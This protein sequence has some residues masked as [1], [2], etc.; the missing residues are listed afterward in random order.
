MS[1]SF[2][3]FQAYLQEAQA[4]L[5]TEDQRVELIRHARE[6]CPHAFHRNRQI[7]PTFG[8]GLWIVGLDVAPG[9]YRNSDS[10]GLC[11]WA[12]LKGFRGDLDDILADS[13]SERIQTVTIRNGDAAFE[14]E[15]CGEWNPI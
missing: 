5:S 6:Q 8:D 10:S 2:D 7:R 14:S 1:L 13:L 4:Q 12:R 9:I 3:R 11:Y 15:R